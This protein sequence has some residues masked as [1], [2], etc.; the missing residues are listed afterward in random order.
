MQT[1]P[2]GRRQREWSVRS[3]AKQAHVGKFVRM[4]PLNRQAMI[5][6]NMAV[7]LPPKVTSLVDATPC[8]HEISS[9]VACHGLYPLFRC[10]C[11]CIRSFFA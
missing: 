8:C 3:V 6:K 7:L 11:V 10:E 1:L 9:R 2:R 4:P 5:E